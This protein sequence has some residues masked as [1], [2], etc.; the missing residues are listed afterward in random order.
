VLDY[1][2]CSVADAGQGP[3]DLAIRGGEEISD[4]LGFGP[5][6]YLEVSQVRAVAK[7]LSTVAHETLRQRYDPAAMNAAKVYPGH[8]DGVRTGD[9]LDWLLQ[10]FDELLR[11]YKGS[12]DRG[13]AVMNYLL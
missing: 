3:L 4:D 10:A 6:R 5:A 2:L 11:F 13:Y 7:A 12:A 9:N 8:W 1:L